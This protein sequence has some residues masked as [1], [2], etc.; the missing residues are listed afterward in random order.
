MPNFQAISYATHGQKRWLRATSFSFAL[1]DGILPLGMAE[2]AKAALTLPLAFIQRDPQG[3]FPVAVMSLKPGTNH[4]VTPDGRWPHGYIPATS[5]AYPFRLFDT[6]ENQHVLAIDEDAGL[7]SDGVDGE[8]FFD[9][10]ESPS[11][12]L[13][14]VMQFLE[15]HEIGL[16]AA[17]GAAT[18]LSEFKILKPWEISVR[19]DDGVQKLGGLF[20]V[21]QQ[22]LNQ[23]PGEALKALLNAGGL[24]LAYSQLLSMQHLPFLGELASAHAEAAKRVADANQSLSAN[25]ELDLEFLKRS[26]TLSFGG[27]R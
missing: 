12:A 3:F 19:N 15:A 14:E 6:G 13:R 24:L 22:A 7:I 17:R 25:G 26:E 20:Q 27:F 9:S 8:A 2:V 11:H 5:R 16:R 21:D 23:L 10:A 4:F 1:R 18:R